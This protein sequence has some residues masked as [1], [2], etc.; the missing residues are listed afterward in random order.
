VDGTRTLN[1]ALETPYT[2]VSCDTHAGPSLEGVLRPY[3]PERYLGDFDEYAKVQ[4]NFLGPEI[5]FGDDEKYA[6]TLS[7]EGH[8]DPDARLRHMDESG[9][10]A[11][12]IFGG[13]QNHEAVPFLGMGF[14]AGSAATA[15]D[16][17]K[18]GERI[19]NDWL[20]DYISAAP[21]RLLGIMQAPL[22]DVEYAVEEIKRFH[23]R[24][25]RAVNFPSPRPDFP[26]YNDPCYEPIWELCS[27]RGLPL[28]SHSGGGEISLG[29]A[30]PGGM[31]ILFSETQW[32]C[33]RHLPQLIFGGVFERHPGL[34]V[35][36][37]EQ[38][39]AWVPIT[40]R[41]YDSLFYS[42]MHD[43]AWH[44]PWPRL[45]SEYFREHCYIAGSFL[46][47]FE[48]AL[49]HEVGLRNLMWGDDYPHVE[50][51]W[52][53]TML[54]LRHT[55]C[56]VPEEDARLILGEN[57]TDVYGFDRAALN[58]VASRIGPLPSQ[59]VKPVD[60]SEIPAHPSTTFRRRGE[61]S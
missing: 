7:C 42:D 27:E 13:G 57:A 54:A 41:E 16:L 2:V 14:D 44:G 50:G 21:A 1:E 23:D 37:T 61:W 45:P 39:V 36:F 26:A 59:L 25:L 4:R 3:C 18:V 11:A 32:M 24:G 6:T 19:W 31:A 12:V 55:F 53:R 38:R 22:W 33:R 17:R 34:K 43:P 8:H 30:G 49:R 47:P 10:A 51:T 48:A 28:V 9:V 60:P 35:V 52:P 40:L 15:R 29:A 5:C 58:D 56:D 46:A 20:T